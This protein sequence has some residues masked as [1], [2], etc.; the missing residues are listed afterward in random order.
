VLV[1]GAEMWDM[2]G[3]LDYCGKYA[4]QTSVVTE[5]RAAEWN[6]GAVDTMIFRSCGDIV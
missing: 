4:N 2:N 1:A 5:P 6:G 3:I